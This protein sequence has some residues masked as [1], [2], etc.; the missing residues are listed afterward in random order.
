ML[1][2]IVA[3]VAGVLLGWALSASRFARL[4]TE[5]DM[6]RAERGCRFLDFGNCFGKL[7]FGGAH[8]VVARPSNARPLLET[9]DGRN[10]SETA[11]AGSPIESELDRQFG[12][13][14]QAELLGSGVL[15]L[16]LRHSCIIAKG[17]DTVVW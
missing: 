2:I 11:F 10:M 6:A 5:R 3:C 4:R 8:C 17:C 12:V 15:S 16:T 14:Q 9:A 1:E 7:H 13:C